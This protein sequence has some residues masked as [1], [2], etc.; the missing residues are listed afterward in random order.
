MVAETISVICSEHSYRQCAPDLALMLKSV[1][2]DSVNSISA[3]DL[4]LMLKSV[5][6]DSVNSI[7]QL[8]IM[9]DG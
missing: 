9:L 5:K 1:K 2:V 6:V 3:P 4:A 8:W 7:S